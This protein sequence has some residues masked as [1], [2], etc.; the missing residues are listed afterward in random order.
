MINS[1]DSNNNNNNNIYNNDIKYN[2]SNISLN[3][4]KCSI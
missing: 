4:N 3:N 1:I 2:K